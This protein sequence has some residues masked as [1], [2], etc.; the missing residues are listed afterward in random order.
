MTNKA[1]QKALGVLV[2]FGAVAGPA[3]YVALD[4][5][6]PQ[7]L[8]S[9][10]SKIVG[11]HLA[12]VGELVRL[13]GLGNQVEWT[14]IPSIT[15]TQSFGEGNT[16]LVLSFRKEGV[17]TV[18]AAIQDDTGLSVEKHEV[19]IGSKGPVT[20]PEK[21]VDQP[22]STVP[23]PDVASEVASLAASA[24]LPKPVALSLAKNFEVVA[25]EIESGRVVT[26]SGVVARTSDLNRSLDLASHTA[27]MDGVQ[28]LLDKESDSGNLGGVYEHAQIWK[29]IAAGLKSYETVKQ[30]SLPVGSYTR[31]DHMGYHKRTTSK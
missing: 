20:L 2:L 22:V 11:T 26:V 5:E 27:F 15:D 25:A 1:L 28:A 18:V 7:P 30:A 13:Q 21:P 8:I 19:Q 23:R 17:Y 29:S 24:A 16:N 6:P 31:A 9:Q 14:T 4:S 3:G 10:E 12:E